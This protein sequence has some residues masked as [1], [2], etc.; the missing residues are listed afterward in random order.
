MKSKAESYSCGEN[1]ELWPLRSK[2]QPATTTF[3]LKGIATPAELRA[4]LPVLPL[5][6]ESKVVTAQVLMSATEQIK[7]IINGQRIVTSEGSVGRLR[8]RSA[9]QPGVRALSQ[10]IR[11]GIIEMFNLAALSKTYDLRM[12]LDDGTQVTK[13]PTYIYMCSKKTR[14]ALEYVPRRNSG[15]GFSAD[16]DGVVE[17]FSRLREHALP[18]LIERLTPEGATLALT[19]RT[20]VSA[21]LV[22][23]FQGV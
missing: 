16:S 9:D 3:F 6:D 20:V 1:G 8:F 12:F 18:R 14:F 2:N 11:R 19:D 10:V 21:A 4:V 22:D 13:N 23:V 5:P 17:R 7:A 15:I